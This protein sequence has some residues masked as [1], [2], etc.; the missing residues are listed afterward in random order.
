[1]GLGPILVGMVG[2]GLDGAPGA[3][4]CCIDGFGAE[5]NLDPCTD[6]G[7]GG[8]SHTAILQLPLMYYVKLDINAI[9]QYTHNT[10]QSAALQCKL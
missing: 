7:D 8:L 3:G 5:P 2:A 6:L 9:H 4:L 10:T 1:M